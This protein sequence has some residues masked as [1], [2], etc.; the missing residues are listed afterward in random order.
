MKRGEKPGSVA[1][2]HDTDTVVTLHEAADYLKCHYMTLYYQLVRKGELRV[3][4]LGHGYR[5]LRSD[6]DRWISQQG[7]LA[8]GNVSDARLHRRRRKS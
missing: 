1:T 3:F 6:I 8:G 5:V 2:A 7:V 4:R